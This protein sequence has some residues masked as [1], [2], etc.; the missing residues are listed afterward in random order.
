MAVHAR[1]RRALEGS[2]PRPSSKLIAIGPQQHFQ[3]STSGGVR[4]GLGRLR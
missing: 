2:H 3:R 4:K 1:Q